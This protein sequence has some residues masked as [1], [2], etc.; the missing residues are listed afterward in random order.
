MHG[1]KQSGQ[2]YAATGF[3]GG[4][5][6]RTYGNRCHGRDQSTRDGRLLVTVLKPA[7]MLLHQEQLPLCSAQGLTGLEP[8]EPLR[9]TLALT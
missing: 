5:H 1:T 9:A 2:F 8:L 7:E 3:D 4:D 6:M